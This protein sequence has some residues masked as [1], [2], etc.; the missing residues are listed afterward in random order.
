MK[1]VNKDKQAFKASFTTPN[2]SK[3]KNL[4]NLQNHTKWI[5]NAR[6]EHLKEAERSLKGV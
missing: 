5:S 2:P 6:I 3:H 4:Q 1:G